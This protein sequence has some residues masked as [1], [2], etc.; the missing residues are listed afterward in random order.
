LRAAHFVILEQHLFDLCHLRCGLEEPGS[1]GFFLDAFD[2]VDGGERISF[3]QHRKA[4]DDRLLVVLF[5]VENRAFGFGD[6]LFASVA[7]PSLATFACEA[8]LA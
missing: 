7:L 5:A 2:A 1:D 8:E 6:N 4:L 3:G